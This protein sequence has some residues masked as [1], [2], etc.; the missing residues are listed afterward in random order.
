MATLNDEQ[1]KWKLH[2]HVTV[3]NKNFVERK[4]VV[5]AFVKNYTILDKDMVRYVQKPFL[6]NTLTKLGVKFSTGES[7]HAMWDKI[8]RSL[9]GEKIPDPVHKKRGR[10]PSV[11]KE[12]EKKEM[13]PASIKKAEAAFKQQSPCTL[14]L[15]SLLREY[16]NSAEVPSV[17]ELRKR[18][19]KL[20]KDTQPDIAD[21]MSKHAHV[22]L[23]AHANVRKK[24]TPPPPPLPSSQISGNETDEEGEEEEEEE[25]E[26][27]G[28][29]T[30]IYSEEEP[31]SGDETEVYVP[32]F[33][34]KDDEDPKVKSFESFFVET[35]QRVKNA[36]DLL[37][38]VDIAIPRFD[39]LEVWKVLQ[40]HSDK[41]NLMNE[42]QTY[43]NITSVLLVH[44][45]V[46]LERAI[47]KGEAS[48]DQFAVSQFVDLFKRFHFTESDIRYFVHEATSHFPP[49][50][51]KLILK[52]MK[53]S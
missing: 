37:S 9:N 11:K 5:D 40:K 51:E 49:T 31:E 34:D 44:A 53:K 25:E 23:L 2:H 12:T 32:V 33:E 22:S 7:K 10:K 16:Q 20:L 42:V 36:Q 17:E 4:R 30:D 35:T 27:Q 38:E 41:I 43:D 50:L 46:I 19:S 52:E 8:I 29:E 26:E 45:L 24:E 14:V 39:N 48:R 13:K 18:A 1:L 47:K 3:N 28:S 6:M 21:A 15:T